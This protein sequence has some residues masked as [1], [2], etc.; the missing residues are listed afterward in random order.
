MRTVS[1]DNITDVFK[2]YMSDDMNP[3]ARE[4]MG[5]LVQHLHDFGLD[6]NLA[7]RTHQKVSEGIDLPFP[8]PK[9]FLSVAFLD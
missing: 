5:S 9:A 4:I 8:K 2:G 6:V 1:K 3:R 7:R